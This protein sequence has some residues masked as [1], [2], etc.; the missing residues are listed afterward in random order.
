[1]EHFGGE[2]RGRTSPSINEVNR[3][4]SILTFINLLYIFANTIILMYYY[5]VQISNFEVPNFDLL[6]LISHYSVQDEEDKD[7]ALVLAKSWVR[8]C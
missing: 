1:M 4:R 5:G 7:L 6:I 2:W 3:N 8:H